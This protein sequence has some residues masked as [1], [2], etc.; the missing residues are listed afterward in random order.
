MTFFVQVAEPDSLAYRLV[1][2]TDTDKNTES[3]FQG[4]VK[5]ERERDKLIENKHNNLI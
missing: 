1:L 4:G 5:R 2:L 3:I